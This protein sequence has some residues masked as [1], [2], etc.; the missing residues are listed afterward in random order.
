MLGQR[1]KELLT[2]AMH[3]T[4]LSNYAA[5]FAAELTSGLNCTKLRKQMKKYT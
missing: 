5:R 1:W 2:T 4:C 3:D